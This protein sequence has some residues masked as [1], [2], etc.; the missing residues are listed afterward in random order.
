MAAIRWRSLTD[1]CAPKNYTTCN[2]QF[3][4]WRPPP[5]L[6]QQPYLFPWLPLFPPHSPLSYII[7]NTW[8]IFVFPTALSCIL[9]FQVK[10]QSLKIRGKRPFTIPI[11]TP[12]ALWDGVGLWFSIWNYFH[13]GTVIRKPMNS[14]I[15]ME[16]NWNE[17]M[18]KFYQVF[19]IFTCIPKFPS[20]TTSTYTLSH[21]PWSSLWCG[22][23]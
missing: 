5:C 10:K 9:T 16:E 7:I 2:L 8:L 12:L 17:G 11:I 18:S 19:M 3:Q 22:I 13:V 23:V 4:V 20:L 1:S 6:T 21:Q 14:T 15:V